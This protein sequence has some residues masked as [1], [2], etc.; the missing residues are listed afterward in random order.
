MRPFYRNDSY[1]ELFELLHTNI[2]YKEER[3]NTFL[4]KH[5]AVYTTGNQLEMLYIQ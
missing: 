2:T 1:E 4:E 5:S 3:G